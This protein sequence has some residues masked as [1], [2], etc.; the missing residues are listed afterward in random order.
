MNAIVC[1]L[2]DPAGMNIF[3]FLTETEFQPSDFKWE[4]LTVYENK[5]DWL[6]VRT[7]K[8]LVYADNLNDLD[9]ERIVFASKHSAA[10]GKPTLTVHVNGNFGPA[11]YGGQP[12]ELAVADAFMELNLFL[13]LSKNP[14][15]EYEVSLEATHHGPSLEILSC[16]IELGSTPE[17]WKDEKAAEYLAEAIL[18]GIRSK[19]KAPAAI[20]IGGGHYCPKLT[21]YEGEYA[22]GHI[23]PKYAIDY[24]NNEISRQMVEKTVP[25]PEYLV[26]DKKGV[27]QKTRILSLFKDIEVV[28]I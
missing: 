17:Q 11:D 12:A 9:V 25:K 26:L 13:Q 4:G 15:K 3:R 24:L 18:E 27:K 5:H 19:E 23:C 6:L 14:P 20:G 2:K 7:E 8:E 10:S 16:W 22:F 28:T 1:S 21:Q